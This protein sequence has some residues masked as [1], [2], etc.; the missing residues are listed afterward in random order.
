MIKESFDRIAQNFTYLSEYQTKNVEAIQE[1]TD[2]TT[3]LEKHLLIVADTSVDSAVMIYELFSNMDKQIEFMREAHKLCRKFQVPP[4]G[5][6]NIL[7]QTELLESEPEDTH[8]ETIVKIAQDLIK[9][10][11]WVEQFSNDTKVYR[12]ESFDHHKNWSSYPVPVRYVGPKW[13][14]HNST[15]NCTVGIEE[16]KQKHTQE[17]CKMENFFD[18]R[19]LEWQEI[20]HGDDVRLRPKVIKTPTMKHVYC[21]Y[22]N[23]TQDG[24]ELPCPYYPFKIPTKVA[25]SI[26]GFHDNE[27]TSVTVKE[28][29]KKVEVPR[30]TYNP[31]EKYE[32]LINLMGLVSNLA[33]ASKKKAPPSNFH[34]GIETNGGLLMTSLGV[35]SLILVTLGVIGL[36]YKCCYVKSP[37]GEPRS[38]VTVHIENGTGRQPTN[39]TYD[40]VYVPTTSFIDRTLPP[41]PRHSTLRPG[42]KTYPD[43]D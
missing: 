6:G 42:N 17:S 10:Q 2:I 40:T 1:I 9:V 33:D 20:P 31:D 29:E 28:V 23:F 24:M 37:A 41:T 15:S 22:H 21:L 3:R 13:V 25:F 18:H 35:A 30:Y 14:V 39:T 36:V 8:L 38:N 27:V 5:L 34:T 16:P 4:V 7:N 26:K 12:V 11:F 32:G 19:I 43:L